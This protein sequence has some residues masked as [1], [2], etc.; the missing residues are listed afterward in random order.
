MTTTCLHDG[1][2]LTIEDLILCLRKRLDDAEQERDAALALLW[3]A[4]EALEEKVTH[5][6]KATDMLMECEQCAG[7]LALADEAKSP[8][9][10]RAVEERG[11]MEAVI[12]AVGQ[13]RVCKCAEI[14]CTHSDAIAL[15][16]KALDAFRS[17]GK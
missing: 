2:H 10:A 16:S 5:H 6:G 1:S 17:G 12:E 15:A 9:L 3:R 11:L 13:R 4:V 14:I 7:F 8:D